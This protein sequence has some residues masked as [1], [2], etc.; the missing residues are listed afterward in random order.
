M[1]LSFKTDRTTYRMI[2]YLLNCDKDFDK[3]KFI[4]RKLNEQYDMDASSKK[5]GKRFEYLEDR[6]GLEEDEIRGAYTS[7]TS[8]NLKHLRDEY[9]EELESMLETSKLN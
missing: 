5:I 6:L 3:S 9:G 8:W 7:G 1:S 2:E 4:A